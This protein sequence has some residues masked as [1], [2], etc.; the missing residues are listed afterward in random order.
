MT[1]KQRMALI[2]AIVFLFILPIAYLVI[3]K[4]K[5]ENALSNPAGITQSQRLTAEQ[6]LAEVQ[7][8]ERITEQAPNYEN[9][10]Q[11]SYLYSRSG[12]HVKSADAASKAVQLNPEKG[13]KA[14][15]NYGVALMMVGNFIK[16]KENFEKAIAIEPTF[17]LGKQ[18]LEWSD[19]EIKRVEK[20]VEENKNLEINE[21]NFNKLITLTTEYQ[22]INRLS[23][24]KDLCNRLIAF[25]PKNADA[26]N[27]LGVC[28]MLENNYAQALQTF[29]FADKLNPNPLTKANMGWAK[30]ELLKSQK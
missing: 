28:F 4:K 29:E 24:S 18:N 26:M 11:L 9:Y 30:A 22:K 19:K 13:F 25:K 21:T 2:L 15:S 16:A 5:K 7:N 17:T 10:L 3:F 8:Y 12:M 23:E 6:M 20:F 1:Y 14:Y 27:N